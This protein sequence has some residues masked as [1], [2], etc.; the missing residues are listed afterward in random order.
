VPV[1]FYGNKTLAGPN[2]L[3]DRFAIRIEGLVQFF[4]LFNEEPGWRI[5]GFRIDK[6]AAGSRYT[7]SIDEAL[8][9]AKRFAK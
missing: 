1:P 7:K 2:K 8:A 6:G 5:K 4:I 9:W 3:Q